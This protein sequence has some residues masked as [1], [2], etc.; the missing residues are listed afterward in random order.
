MTDLSIVYVRHVAHD[1]DMPEEERMARVRAG[2]HH[3]FWSEVIEC[4]E[5]GSAIG[6]EV[7]S[8]IE[9]PLRLDPL[10]REPDLSVSEGIAP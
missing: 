10:G 2:D 9:T 1:I 8:A 5:S 7:A 3:D 4:D 6:I